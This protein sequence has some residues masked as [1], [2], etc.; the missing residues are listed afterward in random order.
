MYN[1]PQSLEEALEIL[2]QSAPRI[3]AGGTDLYPGLDGGPAPSGMLDIGRIDAMRGIVQDDDGWR[4]GAATSWAQ[5][6]RT[7][8][9]A[10]FDGLRAAAREVG[11]VQIQNTGTIGGNLCNASPA[12]DG[13]PPL[14]ALEAQVELR[15]RNGQRVLALTDFL[16]GPRTTTLRP[17]EMLTAVLVP[18]PPAGALGGFGK[19]GTRQYLVISIAM[20]AFVLWHDNARIGGVRVAVG[21]CSPVARRL[22]RLEERLTGQPLAVLHEPDLVT[23]D[24]LAPLSPLDDV[25]GSAEYRMEAAATLCQRILQRAAGPADG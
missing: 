8:L 7:E 24:D 21:A 14:M 13:V 9:P 3:L 17:D 22:H 23:P 16:T 6:A 2:A 1:R 25:R 19:L 11:S 10:A 18:D 4:I 5:I 15:S 20:A 12:A